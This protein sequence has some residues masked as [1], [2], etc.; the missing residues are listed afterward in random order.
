MQPLPQKTPTLLKTSSFSFVNK[1]L[2]VAEYRSF[3]VVSVRKL[4]K[5]HIGD[6]F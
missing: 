3:Y 6:I 4:E 1:N 2:S 5:I